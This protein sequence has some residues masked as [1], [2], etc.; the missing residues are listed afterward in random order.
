MN[1]LLASARNT[2]AGTL[3][4]AIASTIGDWLWANY[5]PDGAV[6]PGVLHGVAIFLLIAV[7]LAG[8]IGTRLAWRRLL[9][10]LPLMGLLI[11]AAFYPIAMVIGYIGGLLVTWMAM[12]IG[13]A[14]ADR[15]ARATGGGLQEALVRGVAAAVL[16]GL[17]FWA[18]SG[19]W[20]N[21][22]AHPDPLSVG[23]LGAWSVAFFPGMAALLIRVDGRSGARAR[24]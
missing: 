11:A 12:W 6:V 2:A 19:I 17:A 10:M 4:L 13:L 14:C 23:R 7:V 18:I 8:A 5:I 15:W 20:T 1:T 22:S 9:P 21:P 3:V 16:S 24:P